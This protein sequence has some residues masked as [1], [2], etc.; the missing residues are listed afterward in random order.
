MR[1]V[2]KKHVQKNSI[3]TI[4]ERSSL[5]RKIDHLPNNTTIPST[6]R[7]SNKRSKIENTFKFE[8]IREYRMKNHTLHTF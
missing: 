3:R 8:S 2:E 5:Y 7:F 1:I 4:N 6:D